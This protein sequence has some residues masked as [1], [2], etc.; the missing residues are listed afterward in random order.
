MEALEKSIK[1]MFLN[2]YILPIILIVVYL[3]ISAT[4]A[5]GKVPSKASYNKTGGGDKPDSD[6]LS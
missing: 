4:K 2:N 5:K 1:K 3:I 6:Y